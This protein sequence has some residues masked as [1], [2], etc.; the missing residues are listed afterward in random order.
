MP[1]AKELRSIA[2]ELGIP[3][4]S[5]MLKSELEAALEAHEV[6]AGAAPK[7]EPAPKVG[8]ESPPTPEP[9]PKVEVQ[10][11]PAAKKAR[12]KV[13]SPWVDYCR[14]YAKD[15]GCTYRD[16]LKNAG[17]SYRASKVKG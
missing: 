10:A 15:N 5:G 13:N 16:A 9:A 3:G 6:G 8:A 12:R 11:E 1:T 7:A 17:E 2:R 4:Y 14:Q